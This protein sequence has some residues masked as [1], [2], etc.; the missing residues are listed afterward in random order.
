MIPCIA[1]ISRQTMMKPHSERVRGIVL[2]GLLLLASFLPGLL[3]EAPAAVEAG[4]IAAPEDTSPPCRLPPLWR[5]EVRGAVIHFLG[6]IH[7]GEPALYPLPEQIERHFTAADFLVVEADVH[8]VSSAQ[9]ATWISRRGRLPQGET[10]EQHLSAQGWQALVR[11]AARLDLTLEGL[12]TRKPWLVAMGLTVAALQEAGYEARW[13]VDRHFLQA[14]ARVDKPVLELEG[15]E[16]Q[17][18]FL[19][20]LPYTVQEA[21][22][23]QALETLSESGEYFRALLE[24]WYCGRT[25]V[26]ERLLMEGFSDSPQGKILYQRLLR[27]RDRAMVRRLLEMVQPGRR[28]FV[29][30]GAAHLLGADSLLAELRDLGYP[31]L[32]LTVPWSPPQRSTPEIPP[33]TAHP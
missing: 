5:V 25:K 27:T 29:V 16:A 12:R 23:E 14:A 20:E 21:L 31:P 17:W 13:G 11:A 26:L 10:L 2:A 30:V 19:D 7:F 8:A 24:A 33:L 1:G 9:A 15:L 32:R 3:W 18:S 6:S 4:E 22:L 28:Y